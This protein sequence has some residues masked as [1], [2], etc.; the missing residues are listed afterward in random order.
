MN[1]FK[2]MISIIVPNKRENKL[3]HVTTIAAKPEILSSLLYDWDKMFPFLGDEKSSTRFK[4]LVDSSIFRGNRVENAK[5]E[6]LELVI[7]KKI[8]L[9]PIL[10]FQEGI[11]GKYILK[12]KKAII[13]DDSF[14]QIPYGTLS[15]LIKDKPKNCLEAYLLGVNSYMMQR[16]KIEEY[17]SS[18]I[19]KAKIQNSNPLRAKICKKDLDK[20]V[21]LDKAIKIV[22]HYLG[23]QCR[24]TPIIKF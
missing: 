5:A 15:S 17:R 12:N 3:K 6:L 19:N 23:C 9:K 18:G 22:P 20:L 2:N 21:S 14:D 13:T 16:Y 24:I 4:Y 1:F 11:K 7:S 10:D 8:T